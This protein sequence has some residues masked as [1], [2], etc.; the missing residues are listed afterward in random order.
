[1]TRVPSKTLKN[2][3][4]IVELLIVVVVIAIL[5]AITIVAYN[6]IQSKARDAQRLEAVRSIQKSLEL[7]KIEN[8]SCPTTGATTTAL[9]GS[10]NNGYSFS[11][12]TD[13]SWL[14]TLL[15]DGTMSKASVSPGNGCTQ[16]YSY[17]SVTAAS[18]GCSGLRTAN[19]YVLQVVA[20]GVVAIPSDAVVGLW[21][22]CTS[23]TA[24][25]SSDARNWTFQKDDV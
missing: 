4:T 19:Y 1:M 6:G 15:A 22:P 3:F 20:D 13:G 12:A 5:A 11:D 2:G 21:R 9:C 16:F 18:Y 10:H 17:L 7:Y 25:W 8:G 23:A 14:S 24:G